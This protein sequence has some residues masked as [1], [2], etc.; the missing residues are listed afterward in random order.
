ML[1][2]FLPLLIAAAEDP[3]FTV[4]GAP[5]YGDASLM[6]PKAHG[7]TARPVQQDL[8]WNVSAA[9]ANEVCSFYRTTVEPVEDA[10]YFVKQTLFLREMDRD[11]GELFYD[12][13]S[14]KPLFAAP[15]NRSADDFLKESFR[16]GWLSFRD[17]EVGSTFYD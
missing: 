10:H 11:A 1:S 8:R 3:P 13:V 6:D 17:A 2:S 9:L 7:T 15:R 16:H 4:G 14:G 12:S 5:V